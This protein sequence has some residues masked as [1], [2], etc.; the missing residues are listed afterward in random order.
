[1]SIATFG[2]ATLTERCN[3]PLMLSKVDAFILAIGNVYS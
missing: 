1:M 3:K 2:A